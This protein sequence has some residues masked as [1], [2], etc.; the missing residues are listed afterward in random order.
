MQQNACVAAAHVAVG[1]MSQFG[2]ARNLLDHSETLFL[3]FKCPS[4][5]VFTGCKRIDAAPGV[6]SSIRKHR[7]PL[8]TDA[9]VAAQEF[10]PLF[11]HFTL[12]PAG[13][14]QTSSEFCCVNRGGKIMHDFLGVS[15]MFYGMEQK[16]AKASAKH[17]IQS[18]ADSPIYGLNSLKSHQ[19]SAGKNISRKYIPK[20][21][22]L[23]HGRPNRPCFR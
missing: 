21:S 8:I 12:I 20:S 13:T 10:I 11:A 19:F 23:F 1:R 18:P 16:R 6:L 15:F 2:Q 17:K 22:Q 3:F 9:L 4:K 7:P 5:A 14:A